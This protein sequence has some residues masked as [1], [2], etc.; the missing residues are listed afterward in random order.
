MKKTLCILIIAYLFLIAACAN[1]Q[2]QQKPQDTFKIGVIFPLTGDAA[3]YGLPAQRAV[4]IAADEINAKGGINNNGKKI[5]VVYEDGKCNPKDGNAAAQKLVNVD[6]VKVIIGGFCSGETLGA[7]PIAE[8]NKVILISPS[9]TSPDITKAGDY[10]FRLAPS[11]AFAGVVASN[12]AFNELKARKAAVISEAT[13]YPQGLRKVFK[14]NF[15]KLGGQIVADEVFNPDD[16]DMRTQITKI[17][18]FSPDVI[19][20]VPQAVQKGVLIIK[21]M[22]EAGLKQQL[23]T[24]EAI[25]GERNIIKENAADMEGIIGIQQKFDD[26]ALKTTALL[27]KYKQETGKEGVTPQY[28]SAAYDSVYLVSKAVEKYGYDGD[29][30]KRFLYTVKDYDGAV[31]RI[32]I[33]QNGDVILDFSVKQVNDGELVT[34][35]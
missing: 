22:K 17:K 2:V 25:I 7:A 10:I 26:K 28:M 8:Q 4:M 32:T 16:T 24:N 23:L 15:E 11:D 6:K 33:D 34:L 31:G 9:S 21:Q 29:K 12:Y 1:T 35:K 5:T 20:V 13:D 14:E 27:D 3:A 19:Y 30:I 18:V